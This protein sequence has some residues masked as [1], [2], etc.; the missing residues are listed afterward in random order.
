MKCILLVAG[1]ATRLYPLTRNVPKALLPMGNQTILDHIM[2]KV[3][4]V[5]E[6]DEVILVSNHGFVDHFNDYVKQRS[7]KSASLRFTVLDDGTNSNDTRLGA[8]ADLAFAVKN[9]SITDDLLVLAGDNL[10]DF[11]LTEF[12]AFFKQKKSDCI[13]AHELNDTYELSRTG[14]VELDATSKV[15]SF[16]EKPPQPKSHWAVP[17][18]YLYKSTSLHLLNEYLSA[19]NNPDAPGN[20]IPFLIRKNPVY[21]YIFKGQRHDIGTLD[22]YRKVQKLY[23]N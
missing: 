5:Q 3:E 13:C 16:E 22:T 18:F 20:F 12:I 23:L 21:A 9:C 14:V 11:A 2:D 1:Y 6:L 10:F 4:Q 17:P 8:V 19:G 15:L 7:K